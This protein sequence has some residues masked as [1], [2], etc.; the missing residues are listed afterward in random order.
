MNYFNTQ[1]DK[2]K[3]GKYTYTLTHVT[4]NKDKFKLMQHCARLTVDNNID[5]C[6]FINIPYMLGETIYWVVGDII[7][8]Q[9]KDL[10]VIYDE[11]YDIGVVKFT[12][13]GYIYNKNGITILVKEIPY[14]ES[15]FALSNK[16]QLFSDLESAEKSLHDWAL[17]IWSEQNSNWSSVG[18]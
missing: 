7:D 11:Q 5:K 9:I 1:Q 6:P 10:C 12:V 17:S 4:D 13:N 15:L 8:R 14:H 18:F 16:D 2:G 3:D